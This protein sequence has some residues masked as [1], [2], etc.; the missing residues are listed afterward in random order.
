MSPS[1][2]KAL[3]HR[4][5][6]AID[7][8]APDIAAILAEGKRLTRRR[9]S[10]T[11]LA[12]AATA[13]VAIVTVGGVSQWSNVASP[14]H[15]TANQTQVVPLPWVAEGVLHLPSVN[16]QVGDFNTLAAVGSGAAYTR[17]DGDVVWVESDGTRHVLGHTY[18]SVIAD[19]PTGWVSWVEM[20]PD[21]HPELVVYDTTTSKD[22][23]RLPL[24]YD[25]PRFQIL[26]AGS[27]PIA[28][29][30]GVVYY[31]AEDGDY[32]WDV[33]AG[34]DP[35]RVTDVNTYLLDHQGGVQVVR[36]H[37]SMG[38]GPN[39]IQRPGADDLTVNLDGSTRLSPDGNHLLIVH[40]SFL[41]EHAE[42]Q[43]LDTRT[44]TSANIPFDPDVT[45]QAGAFVDNT[46]IL[47][48]TAHLAPP[49]TGPQMG[50]FPRGISEGPASILSCTI[51]TG[52]CTTVET[53]PADT[54]QLPGS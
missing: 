33:T 41:S 43:L 46:T 16:V 27:E 51:D 48:T 23:G 52:A 9:R 25:G 34:T 12:G 7:V 6:D 36:Q 8:D 11:L 50:I 29:D 39:I 42:V 40:S 18:G 53:T 47:V 3:F 1:E 28:I 2:T 37:T 10:T 35:Q 14:E 20:G 49:P 44:G 5:R 4:V 22:L 38:Y 19:S 30:K 31:A 24:S 21:H 13:L 32:A 54:I 15:Q 45:V 17:L 26:D